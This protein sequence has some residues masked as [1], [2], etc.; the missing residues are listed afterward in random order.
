MFERV[1]SESGQ[2]IVDYENL[3]IDLPRFKR[4]VVSV[5]GTFSRYSPVTHKFNFQSASLEKIVFTDDFRA[6]LTGHLVGIPAWISS[7]TPVRGRSNLSPFFQG[8]ANGRLPGSAF[9]FGTVDLVDKDPTPFEYRKPILYLAYPGMWDIKAQSLH[10]V[11][12]LCDPDD[13][14]GDAGKDAD[15][16]VRTITEE[17]DVFFELLQAKFLI[18]LG[19]NRRA[20]TLQP[21]ELSTDGAELVSEGKEQ[22]ESAKANL[23]TNFISFA[24]AWD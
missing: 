10:R 24:D 3:E 12:R 7:A 18:S 6:P 17:D 22:W 19:R 16:H 15:L 11:E 23:V 13:L 20:F 4:L 8:G 9:T 1:I 21:L 2:F 5:L 14:S